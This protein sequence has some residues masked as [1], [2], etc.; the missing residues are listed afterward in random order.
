M[1]GC[2]IEFA[3]S[4]FVLSASCILS[5]DNK[6]SYS[7]DRFDFCSTIFRDVNSCC[8]EIAYLLIQL[9]TE[10]RHLHYP[11]IEV[12][13]AYKQRI[14]VFEFKPK[15]NIHAIN[16]WKC[17]SRFGPYVRVDFCI[18]IPSS[19]PAYSTAHTVLRRF[20]LYFSR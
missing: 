5:S 17:N 13:S 11:S 6:R 7:K 3:I 8:Y 12:S 10:A 18:R 2:A 14:I 9:D 16:S 1:G 19:L 15:R 20:F 4:T